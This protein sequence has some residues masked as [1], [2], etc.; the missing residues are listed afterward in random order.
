MKF[1]R[2]LTIVLLFVLMAGCVSAFDGTRKGFV[3]GGGLGFGPIAKVSGDGVESDY[4]K[5]GVAASL[6]I[7]YAWDEQNMIVFLRE[8]IMYPERFDF[9]LL[10][11]KMTMMQGFTGIGYYHYF[12]PVGKSFYLVGGIGLQDWR[13][14]DSDYESNGYGGAILL[15]GGY[16]FVRHVQIHGSLT[17]GKTSDPYFEIDYDNKHTQLIF[18]VSAVAF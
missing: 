4:D 1:T 8:A 13:S 12:G 7:G 17:F 11:K 16:E 18:L 5:S 9:G 6:L 10:S 14:F 2:V 15:G 3:M